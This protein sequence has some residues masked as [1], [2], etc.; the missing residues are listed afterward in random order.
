MKYRVEA[1]VSYMGG[2]EVEAKSPKEAVDKLEENPRIFSVND[3]Y[4]NPIEIEDVYDEDGL[5]VGGW[6]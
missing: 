4:Y 5:I 1:T 2:F 3:I 6:R